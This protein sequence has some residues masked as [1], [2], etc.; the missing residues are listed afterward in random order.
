MKQSDTPRTDA[1]EQF[2]SYFGWQVHADFV[3]D[4]ERELAVVKRE[5]DE[6]R[7][8]LGIERMRLVAS[9][10][11]P[12]GKVDTVYPTLSHTPVDPF[13]LDEV[14]DEPFDPLDESDKGVFLA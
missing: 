11:F 1:A 4:L 8:D 12:D 14:V 3:R 2:V 7:A 5:R 6:A 9:V 13:P 10:E